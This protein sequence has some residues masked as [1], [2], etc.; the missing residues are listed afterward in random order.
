MPEKRKPLLVAVAAVVAAGSVA[1]YLYFKGIPGKLATPLDSAKVVPDEA[2]MVAFISA[3]S[4]NWS[5]LQQF[6]S[7]EAQEIIAQRLQ[8]FQ[9]QMRADTNL[10]FERDLQPWVGGVMFAFLPAPAGEAASEPNLLMVVGI[11][12]KLKALEFAT[13]LKAQ[14]QATVEERQY[15]GIS[16]STIKEQNGTSYSTAVLGDY[17]VLAFQSKLLEAAI[18][19]FKGEPSLASAPGAAEA[20]AK[21]A[22]VGNPIAQ[23]YLKDYAGLLRELLLSRGSAPNIPPATLKQLEQ[24]KSAVMGVGI[25]GEGLRLK[26]LAQ[27]DSQAIKRQFKPAPGK[28][29]AQ[30]PTQTVALLSG[31]GINQYWSEF[32][33]QS[34]NIPE[35]EKSV[36]QIRQSVKEAVKLDADREVFAWMD[37]EFALG[38][39][40]SGEGMLAQVGFGGALVI[41]TS[42]RKTAESSL[43]KLDS[44]A[45]RAIPFIAIEPRKIGNIEV[46][47]WKIPQGVVLG[48]GWLNNDT[49]FVALGG[50]LVD[51]MAG[52]AK[53]PLDSSPNFKAIAGSLPKPNQGYF[54]LDME[55]TLPVV[56]ELS[57]AAGTPLA[58]D[59]SALLNSIRG[60]AIA[61]SLPDQ[62]TSNLEILFSLKGEGK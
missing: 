14:Q 16:V 11:K 54:Y 57:V 31:Q 9:A 43:E 21:S 59:A 15:K 4:Q 24:V 34:K 32:V 17:L 46:R 12:N 60:V 3:D 1:A 36:Q 28:V 19:T 26:A 44:A 25:D 49:L 7:R 51:V 53:A 20:L 55:K 22:G 18:D 45:K 56:S 62:S 41:E 38:A 27:L 47:E 40:S 30:F 8:G 2:L 48:R 52:T 5:K 37:G 29:V 50:P 23:V 6:G 42:N 33:S 39:I 35:L 10:D 58:P 61:A 13:R